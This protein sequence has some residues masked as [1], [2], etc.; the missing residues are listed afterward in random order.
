M[1]KKLFVII[2]IFNGK[3]VNQVSKMKRLQNWA[4]SQKYCKNENT[5]NQV[6][7]QECCKNENTV[8]Q[9]FS[10]EWHDDKL[11][12]EPSEYGGVEEIYVPR[13]WINI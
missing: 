5:E 9:V 11:R 7:S 4:F 12:W 8:N 13:W 3:T 2:C 6:F 10:Q 1:A